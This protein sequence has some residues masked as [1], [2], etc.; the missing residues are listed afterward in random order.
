MHTNLITRIFNLYQQSPRI[1]LLMSGTGSNVE[2]I[3]AQA[4]RYPNLNFITICTDK[5]TSNAEALSKQFG[6]D[7]FCLEGHIKT[8]QDREQYFQQ[9]AYYLH[10]LNINTLI[11]AGFMKISPAFFL[12]EFPGINVHPADLTL[13]LEN[14]KPRYVGMHA[15]QDAIEAG[16]P[17]LASTA[18]VVD[19]EADCGWPIM[20]SKHLLLEEAPAQ[21]I[22]SLHE[23]LKIRCEHTLFPCVLELMSKN[24][25]SVENTPYKW[26]NL[27]YKE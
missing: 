7:Y 9:L 2:V 12:N 14:N 27:P 1:A 26:Q 4:H 5:K 17:Y 21:D 13:K 6:L 11:Y 19:A 25:L 20:I 16:E 10:S 3:L 22:S 8:A 23:E 15:I 18:H 24:Q